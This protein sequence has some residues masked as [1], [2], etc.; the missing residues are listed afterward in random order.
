MLCIGNL[1]QSRPSSP[2]HEGSPKQQG[3]TNNTQQAQRVYYTGNTYV[4][5]TVT[6]HNNV[7]YGPGTYEDVHHNAIVGTLNNDSDNGD[8]AFKSNPNQEQDLLNA[9]LQRLVR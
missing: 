3:Y 2:E 8:N 6:T 1:R 9:S 5:T 7:S 4:G